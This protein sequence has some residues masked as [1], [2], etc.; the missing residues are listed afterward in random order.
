MVG[1]FEDEGEIG[2]G[3]GGGRPMSPSGELSPMK[4]SSPV[5]RIQLGGRPA[6]ELATVM[7]L[8]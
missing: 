8:T 4:P 2:M 1:V 7:L 3:I 5:P 6:K